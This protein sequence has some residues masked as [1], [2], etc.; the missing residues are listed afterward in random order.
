MN[1]RLVQPPKCPVRV[2]SPPEADGLLLQPTFNK[3]QQTAALSHTSEFRVPFRMKQT[4]VDDEE[5]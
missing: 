5:R 3:L 4:M 2:G 1:T